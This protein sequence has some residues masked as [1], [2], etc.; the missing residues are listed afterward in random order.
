METWA[1]VGGIIFA[2]A[3]HFM[4]RKYQAMQQRKRDRAVQATRRNGPH[5]PAPDYNPD[6]HQP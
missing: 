6:R 1:F 3:I 4:Y 5:Q 2:V